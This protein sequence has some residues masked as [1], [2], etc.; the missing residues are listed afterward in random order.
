MRSRCADED[1]TTM[2][3]N[4][5]SPLPPLITGIPAAQHVH[6]GA[7]RAALADPVAQPASAA[8]ARAAPAALARAAAALVPQLAAAA[9]V[10]ALAAALAALARPAH[11]PRVRGHD[12]PA[13]RRQCRGRAA[14]G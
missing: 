11:V 5:A 3:A 2:A 12:A 1:V 10:A 14:A 9:L 4:H 7:V 6:V 13:R 8:L